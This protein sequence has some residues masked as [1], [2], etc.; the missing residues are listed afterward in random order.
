MRKVLLFSILVAT[1]MNAQVREKNDIEISPF[2]G[3]SLVDYY[4]DPSTKNNEAITTP[5]Y[6]VNAVFYFSDRLS[7]KTGMEYR[8]FGSSY[9][10]EKR[11]ANPNILEPD[12][13]II[14]EA[15]DKIETINVPLQ[16]SY[17]IGKSRKWN[18]MF[19]PTLTFVTKA[20][21]DGVSIDERLNKVQAGLQLGASYKFYTTENF[22]LAVEL[23]EYLGASNNLNSTPYSK[24][25]IIAN[26]AGSVNLRASFKIN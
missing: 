4:G 25:P 12:Y 23:Q 15:E 11:V 6:G 5:S 9:N 7:I 19:G 1:S 16:F 21:S 24:S 3:I 13:F 18:I 20:K 8:I 26:L 2:V 14:V 22:N 17:H 10:V